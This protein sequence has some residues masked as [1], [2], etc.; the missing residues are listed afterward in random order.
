MTSQQK[1]LNN[2]KKEVQK[3]YQ[4]ELNRY[5]K[6]IEKTKKSSTTPHTKGKQIY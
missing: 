2:L 1:D 4:Q 5:Y 3:R 6:Q